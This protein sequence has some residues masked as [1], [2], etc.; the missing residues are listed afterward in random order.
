LEKEE[1]N[2]QARGGII[3]GLV[4]GLLIMFTSASFAA[5]PKFQIQA[6]DAIQNILDREVGQRVSVKLDCG[7]ELSGTVVRVGDWVVHLSALSGREFYDAAIRLDQI[8]AVIVRVR[9][10]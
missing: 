10:K 2:M 7:E 3:V 8:S 1:R 6:A 4:I 9:E 5:E